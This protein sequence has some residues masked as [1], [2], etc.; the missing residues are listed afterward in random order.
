MLD[1][2]QSKCRPSP[3]VLLTVPLSLG[4][5]FVKGHPTWEE[6]LGLY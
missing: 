2:L 1:Q 6:M 3:T 4:K 5:R